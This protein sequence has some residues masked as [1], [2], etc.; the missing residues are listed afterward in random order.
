VRVAPQCVYYPDRLG[1][2]FS[3]FSPV[4]SQFPLLRVIRG[5]YRGVASEWEAH[6]RIENCFHEGHGMVL[7]FH[8]SI[9]DGR[10]LAKGDACWQ[11]L[12]SRFVLPGGGLLWG[13][14][15]CGALQP[16]LHHFHAERQSDGIMAELRRGDFCRG[17]RF[18]ILGETCAD[19]N[20]GPPRGH[21]VGY[22][23]LFGFL[24]RM[25]PKMKKV[26]AIHQ[27]TRRKRYQVT[28]HGQGSHV[29]IA[30]DKP[31]IG[32]FTI[33]RVLAENAE[34]AKRLA[35]ETL[36]QEKRYQEL[37]EITA[38]ELGFKNSSSVCLDSIGH[39]SWFR[40]RFG[41]HSPSLILYQ[42]EAK[43]E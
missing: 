13:R 36:E 14:L 30:G 21:C 6:S 20:L 17:L 18:T 32:F 24:P 27:L 41:R 4:A 31:I 22:L 12:R 16:F 15:T 9:G 35:I 37:V 43:S 29:P 3:Q 39:L 8:H 28:L 26:A 40:W 10:A 2:L 23:A 38:E 11:S 34:E 5:L 42:D 25:A 1:P 7:R 19:A 33:R